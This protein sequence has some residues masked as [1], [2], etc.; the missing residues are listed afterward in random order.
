MYEE[1]AGFPRPDPR[2]THPAQLPAISPLKSTLEWPNLIPGRRW[3]A[4]TL[5]RERR[6]TLRDGRRGTRLARCLRGRAR[7]APRLLGRAVQVDPIK[8]MLKPPG[9][10]H[11]KLN[12]GY[13]GSNFCLQ[14]N[15]RRYIKGK[16]RERFARLDRCSVHVDWRGPRSHSRAGHEEWRGLTRGLHSSTFRLNVSTFC[17]VFCVCGRGQ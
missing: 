2:L 6:Q 12:C 16:Y 13:A 5:A 4:V 1:A 14:I 8:P 11:L 9:A 15:L 17:G 7:P 3:L 10:K